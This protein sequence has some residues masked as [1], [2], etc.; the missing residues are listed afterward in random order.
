ME[1]QNLI[2]LLGV[3]VTI[4]VAFVAGQ[5]MNRQEDKTDSAK[6]REKIWQS[7]NALAKEVS[8]F[9]R[10]AAENYVK[11]ETLRLML[12]DFKDQF[13]ADFDRQD[14][15]STERHLELKKQMTLILKLHAKDKA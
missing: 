7:H 6:D 1:T 2:P 15:Q 5:R 3:L 4:G 14:K 9:Q 10:Y 11:S 12:N 13:E 8:E